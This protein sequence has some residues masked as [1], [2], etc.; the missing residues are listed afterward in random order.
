MAED[1]PS[2]FTYPNCHG[3]PKA[4]TDHYESALVLRPTKSGEEVWKD[5]NTHFYGECHEYYHKIMDFVDKSVRRIQ[6]IFKVCFGVAIKD[7]T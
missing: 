6:R 7:S 4:P 1:W 3:F 2:M 5:F